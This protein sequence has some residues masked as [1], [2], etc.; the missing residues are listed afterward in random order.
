LAFAEVHFVLMPSGRTGFFSAFGYLLVVIDLPQYETVALFTRD[1]GFPLAQAHRERV[2]SG[3]GSPARAVRPVAAVV[4]G[5][6]Q[7][8]QI[9]H[10]TREPEA[11]K[12]ATAPSYRSARLT[13]YLP[14][15]P[16]TA[17][18]GNTSL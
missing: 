14:S 15:C 16:R 6:I 10:P 11:A 5:L 12:I 7:P 13:V 4:G 8:R 2:R 3:R 18:A 17:P 1:T 9:G